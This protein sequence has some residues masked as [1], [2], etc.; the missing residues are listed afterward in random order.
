M[1]LTSPID[2]GRGRGYAVMMFDDL[3][4]YSCYCSPNY[5]TEEFTEFLD[6]VETN[7][8]RRQTTD[9]IIASDFKAR[10]RERG[11]RSGDRSGSS[12]IWRRRSDYGWR[13]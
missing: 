13:T 4:I 6:E 7:V 11:A 1:A 8:R 9:V 12:S 5:I 10:A 3:T 2:A